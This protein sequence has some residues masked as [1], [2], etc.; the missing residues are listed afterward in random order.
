MEIKPI[1][2]IENRNYFITDTGI[3]FEVKILG[4][5]KNS[6]GYWKIS[7]QP[8]KGKRLYLYIHRLVY[9]YFGKKKMRENDD[10]HHI[11]IDKDNNLIENLD[12]LNCLTH[13]YYHKSGT[14]F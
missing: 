4:Q 6:K 11:D 13:I 12:L 5:S 2:E 1:P 9:R 8:D 3:V 14:P 7:L 10:V